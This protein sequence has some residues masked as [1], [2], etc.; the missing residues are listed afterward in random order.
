MVKLLLD[1]LDP[2]QTLPQNDKPHIPED[3]HPQTLLLEIL[4][5]QYAV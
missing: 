3:L 2:A 4:S 5:R 1:L